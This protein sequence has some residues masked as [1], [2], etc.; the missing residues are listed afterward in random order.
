[1][2]P[3]TAYALLDPLL[4]AQHGGVG[5]GERGGAILDRQIGEVDVDREAWQVAHEQVD[6]CAALEGKD[7]FLSNERENADEKGDLLPVVVEKSHGDQ[8]ASR[9]A[10]TVIW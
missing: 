2:D 5:R 1:M 9:S 6:R 3:R 10:G 7:S 8:C 4:D